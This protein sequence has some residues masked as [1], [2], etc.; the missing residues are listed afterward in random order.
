ME[1]R[2]GGKC[3]EKHGGR[4]ERERERESERARETGASGGMLVGGGREEE[5][6]EGSGGYKVHTIPW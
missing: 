6:G 4:R 3:T 5:M 1:R 2:K